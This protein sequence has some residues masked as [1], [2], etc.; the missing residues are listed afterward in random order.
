MAAWRLVLL[1]GTAANPWELAPWER[2]HERVEADVRLVVP[3]DNLYGVSS[4]S[5]PVR[6]AEPRAR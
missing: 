5:L 6:R 3:P 2:L 4:V 1:R